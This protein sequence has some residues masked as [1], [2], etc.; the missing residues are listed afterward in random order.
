MSATVSV[1]RTQLSGI[2]RRPGRL[3]MTGLSVLVAAFVVFGTVMAYQITT[4][5][6]LDTF[7]GTPTATSLV[8]QTEVGEFT[9]AQ[10][11]A[12]RA[13]P[14]VAEAV[15]RRD[16]VL[17]LGSSDATIGVSADPGSG[18][19]SRLRVVA[20]SYPARAGELAVDRRTAERLAIGP[21][22]RLALRNGNEQGKPFTV[23]VTA[24]VDGPASS[25]EQAYAP[26]RVVAAMSV[27]K[28]YLRI[29]IRAAAGASTDALTAAV[30]QAVDPKG[31]N[32]A[33]VRTG[34][35]VR[36][37]EAKGQVK[38]FDEIFALIAMFVAIAVIAA[39]LV[40]TSTFRIVFAQRLR[41][42]ALLR[43]IG[44]HRGQLVR[45]LAVE[46]AVVGLVSGTVGVLL[47]LLAG[48][49]APP[50]ARW[51]GQTMSSPG[52]P[53]AAIVAVVLGATLVTLGAVLAPAFSAAGVAPLQALRAA[54]TVAGGRTIGHLRLVLGVLL[55][56]GAV[57]V[58]ALV[59]VNVPAADAPVIGGS[60]YNVGQWL[61]AIVVSGTLAFCALIALGPLLIRPLLAAAGWPLRRLGPTGQLAVSGI[62]GT[63]RRA[64][65]V[66]V[67]VALGVTLVAGTVV[68]TACLQAYVDQGLAV[69]APADF[70]VFSNDKPLP[71]EVVRRL[72]ADP[73]LTNVSP[74]RRI[75]IVAGGETTVAA[76][77]D[78]TA[79]PA[80]AQLATATG[81]IDAVVPG[82]VVL[83]AGLAAQLHRTAGDTLVLSS[84]KGTVSVTVAATLPDTAPLDAAVIAAP[85]DLTRLGAAPDPTGVLVDAAAPGEKGRNAAK[86]AIR[87][88][89]GTD[90]GTVVSDLADER[91]K[92]KEQV[93]NLFLM[94]LGLLGLTVLIAV[95]GVGTTTALS[96]LERT[97]ESGL[98][99]ALGLSRPGLRTMIGVES[100]L[101][102]VIGSVLGLVLGV[103]YAWLSIMVLDLGA[104]LE[105]PAGQLL[106]LVVA[107]AAIT[108]LAG[109][110]PAR[111]AARVSPVVALGTAE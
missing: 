96:V 12:V 31:A 13:L 82:R 86:A 71:G 45:A 52:V 77:L 2:L 39:A 97:Q 38:Q 65:A 26:D 102:G 67:V 43:T 24:V 55:A 76:D 42:L 109:L 81:R 10:L 40:A 34:D 14:G 51:A 90:S 103:P 54:S 16:E 27:S 80:L 58:A 28:T 48:H 78:L 20:G 107:L 25:W 87:D 6:T 49:V 108:A 98:L 84:P 32:G 60:D 4:R 104:P 63:P 15:G 73:D 99:R 3:I 33:S 11:T 111:R 56:A 22:G 79:V 94:A 53:I 100:G 41:Q 5:T 68:G 17:V 23:T 36:T 95:V 75:E 8:A 57:A 35:G 46:G 89:L 88:V 44:A 62:G 110:L 47:A 91:D 101:Y 93:S 83:G 50:V 66:S 59:M 74:Y 105:L 106:V 72:R 18:P 37:L 92:T 30:M 64:A 70:D 85:A 21:G 9:A 61:A 1:L 29:D 7:S 69:S 19:L